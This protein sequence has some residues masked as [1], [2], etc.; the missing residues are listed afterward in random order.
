[1]RFLSVLAL[2]LLSV[3]ASAQEQP[4][5]AKLFK[6]YG[7]IGEWAIDCK[8]KAS[9]ENPH[10]TVTQDDAG[11]IVE[12]HDLGD[13]YRANAYRVLAAKRVS[14]T[15]VSVQALFEPDSE[16][17]QKQD[18]TF[19]VHDGTRRT[20]FTRVEGGPVRVKNGVAVGYGVKTPRL[21]KCG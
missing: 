19:S 15:E 6:D 1:M 16:A 4:G 5:V 8:A 11:N 18:L 14:P 21:K 12:R 7:L 3:S 2:L 17:E 9:P 20:V 13:D 10:V